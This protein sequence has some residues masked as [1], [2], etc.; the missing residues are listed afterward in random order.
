MFVN[1]LNHLLTHTN[2]YIH[3]HK[4]ARRCDHLL[5]SATRCFVM[6]DHCMHEHDCKHVLSAKWAEALFSSRQQQ[7]RNTRELIGVFGETQEI[8]F[9]QSNDGQG[10]TALQ[11]YRFS[12]ISKDVLFM[13]AKLVW[14]VFHWYS[15]QSLFIVCQGK[16]AILF[17][18]LIYLFPFL[19]SERGEKKELDELMTA[20]RGS[21]V[22]V[23][24]KQ[25]MPSLVSGKLYGETA[26][27]VL[28]DVPDS[29]QIWQCF[30]PPF[31]NK[32]IPSLSEPR[33]LFCQIPIG[34]IGI[35]MHRH[36]QKLFI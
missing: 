23:C 26:T 3:T 10:L 9:V 6:I 12:P 36:A 11:T 29:R 33:L 8:E 35:Y 13:R 24:E 31:S 28:I 4:V 32:H 19:R 30:S 27:Q 22:V 2:V 20:V 1:L 15:I 16:R 21:N 25:S 14:T 7:E 34:I 5:R 17:Y 18:S